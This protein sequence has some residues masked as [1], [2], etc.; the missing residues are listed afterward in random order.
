M[1]HDEA[2]TSNAAKITLM[3]KRNIS[4]TFN[5]NIIPFDKKMQK[6]RRDMFSFIFSQYMH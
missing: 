4:V 5:F 1:T 3:R 6:T 2:A